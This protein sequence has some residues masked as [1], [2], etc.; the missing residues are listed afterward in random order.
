MKDISITELRK[1]LQSCLA[2]V[3]RGKRLRVTSRG[4]VIAEITP[5]G[6]DLKQAE[7]AKQ[8]LLGSVVRY[9]EPTAPT[10]DSS[11][12]DMHR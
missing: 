6:R 10:F 8:R 11:E 7:L 12:W 9:D 2:S 3:Q 5:P 4:K 1:H